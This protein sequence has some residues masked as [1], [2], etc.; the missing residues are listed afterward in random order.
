M[1]SEF[2]KSYTNLGGE[3]KDSF[4]AAKDFHATTGQTAPRSNEPNPNATM[5]PFGSLRTPPKKTPK[6]DPISE[7]E[8]L[9]NEIALAEA[10]N[11]D[12][13]K[14]NIRKPVKRS[15]KQSNKNTE[16]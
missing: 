16:Q 15:N 13:S 11:K 2:I 14:R 3:F 4:E 7:Q 10:I 5:K 6:K 12:L 8:R 1:P 9:N